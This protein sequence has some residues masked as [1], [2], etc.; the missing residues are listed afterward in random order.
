MKDII[1]PSAE[2][3]INFQVQ[4]EK[5]TF[6]SQK[7]DKRINSHTVKFTHKVDQVN[8][9]V[10]CHKSLFSVCKF[11][12]MFTIQTESL[13]LQIFFSG[14]FY[15]RRGRHKCP[16]FSQKPTWALLWIHAFLCNSRHCII[17]S[18][19]AENGLAATV[20]RFFLKSR[21][22]LPHLKAFMRFK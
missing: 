3:R 20:K 22:A 13:F 21:K 7:Q 9:S 12:K 10:F 14:H 6:L 19:T 4:C 17:M 18:W 15:M 8:H 2:N 11:W 16:Q 5:N 1:V